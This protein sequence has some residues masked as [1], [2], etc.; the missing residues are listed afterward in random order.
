MRILVAGHF[1][2]KMHYGIMQKLYHA[3]IRLGHAVMLFDD[4]NVARRSTWF[5]GRQM[6]IAPMNMRF[7]QATKEFQPDIIL[8]GHCEMIWNTTLNQIRQNIPNIKIIYR[9][10]DPLMHEK[11]K[12]DIHNRCESVD[13]IFLT[14]AGKDLNTFSGKMA[15]ITHI[16]NPVD[17]AIET[18]TAFNS[19]NY[20]HDLF[21]AIGGIYKNDPRPAVAQGIID[22]C[23]ATKC[24]FGGMFGNSVFFGSEYYEKLSHIKM[25]LNYSRENN[26]YLYSSDRMSQ[27]MGNGL[28]TFIHRDTRFDEL[29]ND[30]EVAFFSNNNELYEKIN[31]YT[32][33]DDQRINVARNGWNKIHDIFSSDTVAQYILDCATG[34]NR[35]NKY[36]WPID[37]F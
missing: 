29:F 30:D 13:W 25:G 17:K 18:K 37:V 28:L 32:K 33:N 5:G 34:E 2:Y 24:Y 36:A 7:L 4:R 35:D 12:A 6:G 31:F 20:T 1:K 16:P 22:S 11:N 26:V 27:Y 14:T 9:N 21:Y 10:V 23:P 8:L 3:F 19:S 15:K